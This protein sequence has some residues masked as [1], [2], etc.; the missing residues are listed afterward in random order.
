VTGSR[1]DRVPSFVGPPSIVNP[2]RTLRGGGGVVPAAPRASQLPPPGR[3]RRRECRSLDAH[4]TTR[5]RRT[6]RRLPLRHP[7]LK[8]PG[9][10]RPHPRPSP[11]PHVRTPKNGLQ[12]IAEAK[13]GDRWLS[14]PPPPRARWP[15]ER[16]LEVPRASAAQRGLPHELAVAS[17]IAHPIRASIRRRGASP[18]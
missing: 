7:L 1:S 17:G 12:A 11:C 5:D 14:I 10:A 13:R 9:R 18:D 16:V 6:P 8:Q 15:N 2:E 4:R 3:S